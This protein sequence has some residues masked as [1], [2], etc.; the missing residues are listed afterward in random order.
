MYDG[1]RRSKSVDANLTHPTLIELQVGWVKQTI[2]LNQY[3]SEKNRSNEQVSARDRSFAPTHH[4]KNW[5]YL[6]PA[7]ALA[8]SAPLNFY[9]RSHHQTIG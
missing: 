5:G 1:L 3:P 6:V 8:K 7:S 2:F 4:L 9:G